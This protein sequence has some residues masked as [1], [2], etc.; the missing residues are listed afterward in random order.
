MAVTG[1]RELMA[2]AGA[3]VETIDTAAAMQAHQAGDAVFVDVREGHEWA[4]GHIPGAVHAPR[5]FL[6]FI[7]D[8][9]GPMH[10]PELS[11]GRKLMVYCGS[12]GRSLL[13]A[14]TL[15]DMGITDIVNVG[16]GFQSWAGGGGA[17]ES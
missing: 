14:K 17:V 16:G 13:A 9:Q 5:G 15:H 12:G 8:P 4:Q 6:E 11:S 10:K 1:F 7:A 2:A 3:V